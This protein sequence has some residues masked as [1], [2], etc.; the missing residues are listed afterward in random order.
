MITRTRRRYY[1]IATFPYLGLSAAQNMFVTAWP[2][3]TTRQLWVDSH[4]DDDK[5]DPLFGA[6]RRVATRAQAQRAM[7]A[8][9]RAC[10]GGRPSGRAALDSIP[11]GLRQGQMNNGG[12]VE[13]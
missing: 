12:S 5:Y 13:P 11:T 10:L 8:I 1:A 9:V 2:T 3:P 7:A 6:V 4:V